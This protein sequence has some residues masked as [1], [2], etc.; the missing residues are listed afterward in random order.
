M[1]HYNIRVF[2]G[3]KRRGVLSKL[4]FCEKLIEALVKPP[5]RGKIILFLRLVACFHHGKLR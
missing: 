3:C 1:C 2:T 4:D 5:L